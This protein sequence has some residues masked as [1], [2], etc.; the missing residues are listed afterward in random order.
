MGDYTL[1]LHQT[2]I[3][4]MSGS[5]KSTFAYRLLINAP[6]ACRFVFDDLGR[7]AVRLGL[8]PCYT[9]QELEAAL[10]TRWVIFNPHRIFEGETQKAF[11]WFCYWVYQVSKRGPG[12]KY[13]LVDEI[14]QWQ[15]SYKVPKELSTVVQTGREEN[16]ELVSATQLPHKINATITGQATELVCFRIQEPLAL[17]RLQALG[18][19]PELVSNLPMGEFV[20]YNRIKG[21][22]MRGR[23]F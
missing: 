10:A 7:A 22:M 15:D 12:K 23:V 6:A 18:A 9:L 8:R 5:G 11:C 1:E 16:I 19:D 3:A 13:F 2:C 21:G 4:G 17:E 20:S 14:W